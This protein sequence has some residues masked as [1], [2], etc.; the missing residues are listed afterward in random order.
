M[1]DTYRA[2]RRVKMAP[3]TWRD[4]PALVPEAHTWYRR[5]SIEHTG[6]IEAAKDVDEAE[7]RA[8]VEQYCPELAD[9][10]YELTGMDG[11]PLTGSHK[12]PRPKPAGV[13]PV[14]STAKK[15]AAKKAT[16]EPSDETSDTPSDEQPE[17]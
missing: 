12:T 17:D 10:I 4:P 14:K 13:Q 2:R 11:T 6:V 15:A 16:A 8:A 9:R 7:F 3:D 1:V 5:E